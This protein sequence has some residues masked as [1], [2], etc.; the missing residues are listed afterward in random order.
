MAINPR[1]RARTE[2]HLYVAA[3]E[4]GHM[5]TRF[6]LDE[7]GPHGVSALPASIEVSRDPGG[8]AGFVDSKLRF[9]VGVPYPPTCLATVGTLM[10]YDLIEALGGPLAECRWL[11]G[12][13]P[14]DLDELKAVNAS[15]A[16]EEG[17]RL[18]G[19]PWG[20]D[21]Y[22]VEGCM[23]HL[24]QWCPMP[25]SE[26]L[27]YMFACARSIVH[28]EWQGIERMASHL[29]R[30]G[31]MTGE[32]FRAGWLRTRAGETVRAFRM[33]QC[34]GIYPTPVPEP[35]EPLPA[36]HFEPFKLAA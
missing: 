14:D 24:A 6:A 32:A 35:P 31:R 27:D 22:N 19:G 36:E 29:M 26:Q 25:A 21:I 20:R 10:R 15:L 8:I 28:V 13:L 1:A 5:V 7:L 3:H 23:H 11:F 18:G 34:E 17:N 4:C 12:D 30:N 16:T 33:R 9:R 2:R